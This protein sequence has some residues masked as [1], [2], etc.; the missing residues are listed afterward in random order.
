MKD[1]LQ[2]ITLTN[3]KTDSWKN[4]WVTKF[5]NSPLSD[6]DIINFQNLLMTPSIHF[7]TTKNIHS[8]RYLIKLFLSKLKYY[9]NVACFTV[10]KNEELPSFIFDFFKTT[11]NNITVMELI[12]SLYVEFPAIDFVL[13]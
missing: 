10:V 2:L 1:F 5:F 12:E 7:I 4:P 8:G 11:Q 9:H 13:I 6:F 3:C